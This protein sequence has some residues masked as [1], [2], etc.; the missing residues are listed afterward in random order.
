MNTISDE[1]Q[2]TEKTEQEPDP[3]VP[4]D[5]SDYVIEKGHKTSKRK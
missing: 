5:N 1:T 4:N 3:Y 2:E